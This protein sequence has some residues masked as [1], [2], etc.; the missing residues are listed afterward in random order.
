MPIPQKNFNK[1]ALQK[2]LLNRDVKGLDSIEQCFTVP[3]LFF[4]F[5][6][7]MIVLALSDGQSAKGL[8]GN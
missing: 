1:D 4:S 8:A 6:V 3:Q 2:M 5:R 7:G